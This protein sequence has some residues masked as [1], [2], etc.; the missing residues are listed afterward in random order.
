MRAGTCVRDATPQS[1]MR[2]NRTSGSESGDSRDKGAAEARSESRP[3]YS[4][5]GP[6][7]YPKVGRIGSLNLVKYS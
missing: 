3:P 1:R 7:L 2:E 5:R 6:D 4:Q